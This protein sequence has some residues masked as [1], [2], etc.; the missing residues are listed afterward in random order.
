MRPLCYFHPFTNTPM[1]FIDFSVQKPLAIWDGIT[2]RLFHSAQLTF[3]YVT[4]DEGAIV[5]EHHHI[6]EQWTHIIE[7][8]L[9]F[10]ID[11]E[12]KLLTPGMCAFM[13]SNA[14]H[15]AKAITRCRVIDCFL[16]VRED[17]VEMEKNVK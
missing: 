11:S 16:P 8:Q 14:V 9:L 12:E 10:T 17:W 7:G 2:A 5:K 3:G 4:L 15:S 6:H 1:P 13:P